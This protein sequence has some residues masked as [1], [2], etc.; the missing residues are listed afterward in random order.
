MSAN[1]IGQSDLLKSYLKKQNY[2]AA[3]NSAAQD[4]APAAV[5]AQPINQSQ[6]PYAVQPDTLEIS[7]SEIQN[8]N[9]ADQK[10]A[11][12][13]ISKKMIFAGIGAAI[14][15]AGI[16]IFAVCSRKK[17]EISPELETTL[18]DLVDTANDF[19]AFQ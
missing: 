10:P 14:I 15:I 18:Q 1:N 11:K 2:T 16:I 8:P 7:K 5:K 13:K 19:F 17:P 12:K 6:A 9:P 4:F 3:Q